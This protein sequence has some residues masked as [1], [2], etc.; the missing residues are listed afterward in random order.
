M[1]AEQLPSARLDHQE[2][3]AFIRLI[4]A[5]GFYGEKF[6]SSVNTVSLLP[7]AICSNLPYYQS[8]DR[9]CL[10]KELC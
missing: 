8:C 6:I 5:V 4:I 3:I 1:I 7:K 9:L 2:I 10:R